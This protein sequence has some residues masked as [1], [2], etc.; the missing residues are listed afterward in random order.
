MEV[1][2][3]KMIAYYLMLVWGA[4]NIKTNKMEKYNG[5]LLGIKFSSNHPF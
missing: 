5:K 3:N 4:K 1:A 2:F